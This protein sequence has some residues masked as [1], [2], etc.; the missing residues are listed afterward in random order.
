MHCA[1]CLHGAAWH[2]GRGNWCLPRAAADKVAR[3]HSGG[4]PPALTRRDAGRCATL[5]PDLS[6]KALVIKRNYFMRVVI[7]V[8]VYSRIGK[9]RK[10]LSYRVHACSKP[11]G[12]ENSGVS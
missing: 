7:L 5:C 9:K 2:G 12:S 10:H 4:E 3:E 8:F 6:L 1:E 11:Q